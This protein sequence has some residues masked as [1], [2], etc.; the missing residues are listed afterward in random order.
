MQRA[1]NDLGVWRW[2]L[3][4][5]FCVPV[6]FPY[7]F[8][9]IPNFFQGVIAFG[10]VA[11]AAFAI[12][13]ARLRSRDHT[14]GITL[15]AWIPL[16]LAALL[17]V[18]QLFGMLSYLQHFLL[19]F[20]A[21]LLAAMAANVAYH[22]LAKEINVALTVIAIAVVVAGVINAGFGVFQLAGYEIKGFNL[23]ERAPGPFRVAGLIAQP[24]QLAV[25]VIWSM[26]G[27]LYLWLQKRLSTAFSMLLLCIFML[28][29]AFAASRATY[30]YLILIGPALALGLHRVR[31]RCWW[32]PV[33]VAVAYA[34]LD[35]LVR[36]LLPIADPAAASEI[37]RPLDGAS[38]AVRVGFI[39]DGW[40]LFL[41]SPILGVGWHQ[42]IVARWSLSTAT[43][44]ELHADHSHN[45]VINMLAETGVFGFAIVFVGVALWAWR[46]FSVSVT[47]ERLVAVAMLGVVGLYSLFEFP[48]W[49]AHFLLPVA[50]LFGLLET[51]QSSFVIT[52]SFAWLR[53][54]AAGALVGVIGV[55]AYDYNRVESVYRVYFGPATEER[56]NL[57]SVLELTNTTLFREEAEQV[58]LLAAPIDA[59]NASF[60]GKMSERVFSGFPAPQFAV[61]HAAHV[62]YSGDE[63]HAAYILERTCQWQP[64]SCAVMRARF[65]ELAETNGEPFSSFAV[66]RLKK[67]L[68]GAAAPA[69]P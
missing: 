31:A 5:L 8:L 58:F 53:T 1:L 43:P 7:R 11:L 6:V 22:R 23:E 49:Y 36:T 64:S 30:I 17:A 60:S 52:P 46:A 62:L 42:F 28:T 20:G 9:P 13:L 68:P 55:V 39:R 48:L 16:L 47:L 29:L 19:P 4:A 41:S 56:P 24:N 27:L 2:W 54:A 18:Q 40:Q 67:S 51:R 61:V 34:L 12:A 26:L 10:L 3:G 38:A 57:E 69:S 33:A 59:F 21:L 14:V 15:V 32:L 66:N 25:L 45:I 35:V 50:V 37:V 63:A 44:L 65:E